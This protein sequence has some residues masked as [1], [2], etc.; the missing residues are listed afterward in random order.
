VEYLKFAPVGQAL[1]SLTNGAKQ[2]LC[3]I[4]S[5]TVPIQN[6]LARLSL[7]SFFRE[8]S[9]IYHSLQLIDRMKGPFRCYCISLK[10]CQAQTR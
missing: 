5:T 3:Y 8:K 4:F 10:T 9:N 6:K 1:A 7:S 2:S